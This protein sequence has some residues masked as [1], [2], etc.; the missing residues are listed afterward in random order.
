MPALRRLFA[1][2][3]DL[4]LAI[5]LLLLIAGASALGTIL[6]QNEAPDLYLERFNADPWLGLID[7]KQMLQ[8]QLDSIYSSVWFLSLLAWLG[9]AL[10]LCSWRR[11]WPALIATTRWID[12]RQPRQLSKLALAE[13][14]RCSDGES[15]LDM[16]SS[17]L[18]KQG[19]Q[20]QR[21]EDRLAARRAA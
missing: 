8:L 19:W 20:V 1:L 12:Y 10:I 7:G 17:Q 21:H 11:Q 6:P 16:L 5:L 14:I 18:Q 13:S 3:S 2:L 4:R 9:L 15:A